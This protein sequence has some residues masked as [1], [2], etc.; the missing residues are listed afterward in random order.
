MKR[1]VHFRGIQN[2]CGAGVDPKTVRDASGK[3]PYKWPCLLLAGYEP[4]TTACASFR[5]QTQA[6]FE[7]ETAQLI[8]AADAFEAS[9]AAGKCPLCG[10]SIQ[11]R[12][13]VGRCAYAEPCGHRLGQVATDEDG[14][15]ALSAPSTPPGYAHLGGDDETRRVFPGVDPAAGGGPR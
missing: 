5:Q 6:E 12:R 3:G 11:S 15:E 13:T 7:A 2:V 9:L 14:P 1:C 10:A 8:A 4:A